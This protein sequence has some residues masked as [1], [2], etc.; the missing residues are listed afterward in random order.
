MTLNQ[1]VQSWENDLITASENLLIENTIKY[2]QIKKAI[3]D[4]K[5]KINN[6]DGSWISVNREKYEVIIDGVS[7]IFP[8]K[9]YKMINYFIENPN[10]CISRNELLRNCWEDGVIVGD[11]TI[12]VHVCKLKRLTK[13]KLNIVT[14]KGYGYIF[15]I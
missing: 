10:R 14:H 5:T 3:I 9:I 12:D 4:I 2:S 6:Q 11:R 15:K 1:L 13:K 7:Y 8:K